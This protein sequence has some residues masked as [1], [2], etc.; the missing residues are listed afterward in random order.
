M[1]TVRLLPAQFHGF[2]RSLELPCD[3]GIRKT[4]PH[5]GWPL[6]VSRSDGAS[7]AL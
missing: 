1:N 2:E 3:R 7:L 5:F 6:H 4:V